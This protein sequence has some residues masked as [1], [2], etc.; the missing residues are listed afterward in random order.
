MI[1]IEER[2]RTMIDRGKQKKY[3]MTK[4]GHEEHR[5]DKVQIFMAFWWK[6][7]TKNEQEIERKQERNFKDRWTL[8]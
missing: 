8:P 3:H 2:N 4:N 5:I 1:E 6:R 7:R